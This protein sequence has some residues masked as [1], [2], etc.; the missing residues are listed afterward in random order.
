MVGGLEW[1]PWRCCQASQ[2]LRGRGAC[3]KAADSPLIGPPERHA[4]PLWSPLGSGHLCETLSPASPSSAAPSRNGA[5]VLPADATL[6]SPLPQPCCTD[7]PGPELS[8]QARS[9]ALLLGPTSGFTDWCLGRVL[10]KGLTSVCLS[11][12]P[13]GH[14]PAFLHITPSLSPDNLGQRSESAWPW[15]APHKRAIERPGS[16]VTLTPGGNQVT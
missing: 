6:V 15:H 12:R 11:A 4:A 5:G 7:C 2:T 1:A 13:P 10:R 3:R 16:E 14:C 9:S 8:P